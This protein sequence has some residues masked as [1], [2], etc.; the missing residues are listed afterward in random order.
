[1]TAVNLRAISRGALGLLSS[2]NKHTE[3]MNYGH[4]VMQC[5]LAIS[6]TVQR[7]RHLCNISKWHT[8]KCPL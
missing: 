3:C 5:Y 7:L 4:N 1:M 8:G 6:S 2:A